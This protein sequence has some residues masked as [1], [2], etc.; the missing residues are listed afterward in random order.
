VVWW[1]WAGSSNGSNGL[2]RANAGGTGF[3]AVD[4]ATDYSWMGPRVDDSAVYYFHGGA[5]LK[6]LK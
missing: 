1:F 2:F 5:L 3:T 6:R 4:T